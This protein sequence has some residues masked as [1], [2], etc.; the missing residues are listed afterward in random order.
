MKKVLVMTA[1]LVGVL[2]G[3][4]S[5]ADVASIWDIVNKDG[6]SDE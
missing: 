3:C 5:D 4:S 1:V 2:A 6:E